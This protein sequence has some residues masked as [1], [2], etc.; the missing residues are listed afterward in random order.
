M[1]SKSLSTRSCENPKRLANSRRRKRQ[2]V[3]LVSPISSPSTGPATASVAARGRAPVS[4]R[5]ARDRRIEVGDRGRF[6]SPRRARAARPNWRARTGSCYRRCRREGSYPSRLPP[7]DN[8]LLANGLP[9]RQAAIAVFPCC[10]CSVRPRQAENVLGEVGTGSDWSRS[11]RSDR[12]A[13]RETCA[14]R[15]T[16]R[17]S[18]KPPWV[19][20][21]HVGRRPGRVG[22]KELRHVGFGAA[23][24]PGP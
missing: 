19:C 22:G 18:R 1:A 23:L 7:I 5:Y 3:R 24:A 21:H 15:R 12:A 10:S 4:S 17:Q 8:H 9:R 16:P 20:R 6:R 14:R 2:L 11:A 13:S